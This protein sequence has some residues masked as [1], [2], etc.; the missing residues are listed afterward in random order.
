M[1]SVQ[2]IAENF[3]CLDRIVPSQSQL[4]WAMQGTNSTELV[5]GVR[6]LPLEVAQL[7][8]AST[9]DVQ[10]LRSLAV[11][12]PTFYKAFVGAQDLII[13]A[14][15]HNEFGPDVLPHAQAAQRSVD[16]G[17]FENRFE[18]EKVTFWSLL[19]NKAMSRVYPWQFQ[20]S[21]HLSE[22]RSPVEY[23]V[24]QYSVNICKSLDFKIK[25]LRRKEL[26]R[27][28][29]TLY[30]IETYCNLYGGHRRLR[31]SLEELQALSINQLAPWEVEQMVSVQ[32]FLFSRLA[33]A[34]TDL[35]RHDIELAY[36]M[37]DLDWLVDSW[38]SLIYKDH[39][40][41][42]GLSFLQQLDQTTSFE[43]RVNL[44]SPV[45]RHDASFLCPVFALG[46]W[47]EYIKQPLR[48]YSDDDLLSNLSTRYT[49]WDDTAPFV[50]WKWA[51]ADAPVYPGS[52]AAT[53][54]L[55]GSPTPHLYGT[56]NSQKLREKGY[57]FLD[58]DRVHS[59]FTDSNP[60][61][62][63][64][65]EAYGDVDV[66]KWRKEMRSKKRRQELF[67]KGWRGYWSEEDQS[68]I[69]WHTEYKTKEYVSE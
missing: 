54:H 23:F 11:S 64:A 38:L 7:L 65:V 33:E 60:C 32:D 62:W 58:L 57:V 24:Q 63:Y 53:P 6:Q 40:L 47:I 2:N 52:A 19:D 9:P 18:E 61:P 5:S 43:G 17:L 28:R 4:N 30:R 48:E 1:T 21:L 66:G 13:K 14:V 37:L 42:R 29:R 25:S 67:G 20:D 12:S 55:Y 22:I 50:A 34:F 15:L 59:L 49:A 41:S 46:R 44:L 27:I 69:V 51:H 3:R 39:Q 26:D 45:R 36:R 8:L 16:L 56:P 68:R 35:A 31:P 10:S